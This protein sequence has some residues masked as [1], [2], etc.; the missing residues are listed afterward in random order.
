M[1]RRSQL[2][3]SMNFFRHVQICIIYMVSFILLLKCL[4]C[5]T[6]LEFVGVQTL[7]D[8]NKSTLSM[9]YVISHVSL[10]V[11]KPDLCHKMPNWFWFRNTC[12][13]GAVWVRGVEVGQQCLVTRVSC[14]MTQNKEGWV[15][16]EALQDS[17]GHISTT[18]RDF[19]HQSTSHSLFAFLVIRYFHHN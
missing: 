6:Q 3:G 11:K 5:L 7:K 16:V 4:N 18:S 8:R 17:E 14:V 15:S 2:L 1:S 10:L 9:V 12:R 13:I 19:I